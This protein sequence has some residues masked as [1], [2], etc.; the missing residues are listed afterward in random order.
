MFNQFVVVGKLKEV[1]ELKETSSGI[2]FASLTLD[3]ERA[4]KNAE[5][6]FDVDTIEFSLWRGLA[7]NFVGACEIGS[8]LGV[9]GRIQSHQNE[10]DNIYHYDFI[11]ERISIIQPKN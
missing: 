2:K 6:I 7:E 3:V 9:K 10:N 4:Y 5:G 1:T 11:A 8:V